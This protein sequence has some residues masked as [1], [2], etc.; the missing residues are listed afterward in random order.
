MVF[1][2]TERMIIRR[3]TCADSDAISLTISDPDVMYAWERT[4]S[5]DE[6][7]GGWIERQMKRYETDGVGYFLAQNKATGEVIGQMG[8]L[9]SDVDYKRCL[10]VGYIVRKSCWGMG[11][12]TEG[13]K[14]L[15][16]WAINH[17][18]VDQVIATIRP[19]NAPSIKVAAHLGMQ[20]I[21]AY[22]KVAYGKEMKHLIYTS[23]KSN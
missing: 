14:A 20:C 5:T 3:M 17:I 19:E 12:A 21:G 9:W 22:S 23:K 7:I 8:L 16:E 4:F 15:I 13:A 10:E 1:L 2:E 18:N 11:Y 6:E